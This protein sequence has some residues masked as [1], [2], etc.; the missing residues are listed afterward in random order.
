M[1]Q[2]SSKLIALDPL[3]GTVQ[4]IHQ[5]NT[6]SKVIGNHHHH[7]KNKGKGNHSNKLVLLQREDFHVKH[8]DAVTGAEGW[9]VHLGSIQALELPKT[10]KK[11]NNH[12]R[13]ASFR[14]RSNVP[15]EAEIKRDK[16]GESGKQNLSSTRSHRYFD[17]PF[18]SVAFGKDG[19]SV[20]L[21]DELQ[22]V[23]WVRKFESTVASVYGVGRDLNWVDLQ[24][25]SDF[26]RMDD[27][28]GEES[29][30]DSNSLK[31]IGNR[32]SLWEKNRGES[33]E[34]KAVITVPHHHYDIP[35][36][37]ISNTKT[38][39]PL[40]PVP[41]ETTSVFQR[42]KDAA[43]ILA[44][45][46]T[47][48]IDFHD[49]FCEN[50]DFYALLGQ[51][52]SSRFVAMTARK[53][54]IDQY[55]YDDDDDDE[56]HYGEDHHYY[57]DMDGVEESGLILRQEDIPFLREI[58]SKYHRANITHKTEYG[59]FLTWKVVA[60]SLGSILF[61]VA[62]GAR[63]VYVRKK[64]HW[65]MQSSPDIR[66]TISSELT[67]SNS[68]LRS[69]H[70]AALNSDMIP[71]LN[72]ERAHT[73]E[74]HHVKIEHFSSSPI[75]RST[76]LPELELHSKGS[77][78]EVHALSL[79]N[80]K[81]ENP[82]KGVSSELT[83]FGFKR[84]STIVTKD[85]TDPSG[86]WTRSQS[87]EGVSNIDGIPLIR[88]SRYRSEFLEISPLG[89]GGFGTVFKCKNALDGR[90]YA[91]KKVLI[92][93]HLDAK[94]HL[95][96]K[97]SQKLER[98][99]R[100][101]KILALLDH[102]N[103]VRYYTA[104]LEVEAEEAN[105]SESPRSQRVLSK[106][107]SSDFLAGSCTYD[108]MS[109]SAFFRESTSPN[110]K[111][112]MLSSRRKSDAERN[113]LGW[114]SFSIGFDESLLDS[115][116]RYQKS[117]HLLKNG[118]SFSSFKSEDDLGFTFD[119]GCSFNSSNNNLYKHD[120]SNSNRENL[121]TIQDGQINDDITRSYSSAGHESLA[122]SS[123]ESDEEE[124]NQNGSTAIQ[125]NGPK[126]I[127][128]AATKGENVIYQRHIL[129]IQMQLSQKTLLD[130]FQ[131]RDEDIDIPLSL[132]MFCHIV[133]GVQ[134]VHEKGLIHRDLKP[135][136]CFMDDC[137]IVKIGDFGLSRESGS[138]SDDVEEI[139]ITTTTAGA[140]IAVGHDNTAGVGTSSYASPEQINGSDYD[141]SSD[142]YS[143]GIIL[144]ELCYP[145]RTGMERF[146]VFEGIRR[147]SSIFPDKWHSAVAN[148]FPSLHSLLVCMLSHDPKE[149]PTASEVASHLE[150][151]LSEYTVHSLDPSSQSDGVIFL[152]VEAEDNEGALERTMKIIKES[153]PLVQIH[154]YG[155]RSKGS[156]KIM[157][158]ALSLNTSGEFVDATS[159]K[160][161]LED[162]FKK[163]ES[164][165]EIKVVRLIND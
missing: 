50:E 161:S 137:N 103:I 80:T 2:V 144:F 111:C 141:S 43:P 64:R 55:Y 22:N 117:R 16:I 128:Q 151:L 27:M 152:R 15:L 32:E 24:V 82:N 107:L 69:Q 115:E 101:V 21:L 35:F 60:I 34:D 46:G 31:L 99:L 109:N 12:H 28:E 11:K 45:T 10:K 148:K 93:S 120:A 149:R 37:S 33:G 97:F 17:R 61:L 1:G 133:R 83:T 112:R 13:Q 142:V 98:V 38:S 100:E 153:P 19:L 47:G 70:G 23:L 87:I 6:P 26:D 59:L 49:H 4:W 44:S 124:K 72:L 132:R 9:K 122:S 18:P 139:E 164:R 91:V 125:R 73:S 71:I 110:R 163:L 66:P 67:A 8:I 63:L 162:L 156:K 158:F 143:L 48:A 140:D 145:M 123:L 126:E 159:G 118:A 53:N 51:H 81:I 127:H 134:H 79:G 106:A 41:L 86:S 68:V 3:H 65:M 30:H 77:K 108:E 94:G 84:N 52:L 89:K 85:A 42:D 92:R 160:K 62:L 116:S 40:T 57:G 150:S 39:Q 25:V 104:W 78:E 90:E 157:E 135:S 121:S 129:Y 146:K 76:S 88:Y 113:P 155:L 96:A 165:D 20:Y 130:Y 14:I 119:R 74:S 147:K 58:L 102:M 95:P 7:T 105:D 56:H 131:S 5:T 75:I 136:N 114:N 54:H 138:Q 36:D 29:F 154:Q